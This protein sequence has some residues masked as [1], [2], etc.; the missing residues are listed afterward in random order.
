[1]LEPLISEYGIMMM[2]LVG[3]AKNGDVDV[4]GVFD[5]SGGV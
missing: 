5:V 4:G 2:G 3:R 1:M